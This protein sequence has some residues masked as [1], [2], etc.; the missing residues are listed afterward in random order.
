MRAS[1][2]LPRTGAVS[3]TGAIGAGSPAPLQPEVPPAPAAPPLTTRQQRLAQ[4]SQILQ[5]AVSKK[6]QAT[7]VLQNMAEGKPAAQGSA[8]MKQAVSQAQMRERQARQNA[9]AQTLMQMQG[10]KGYKR[11]G[12]I[13]EAQ[14]HAGNYPKGHLKF[15]GLDISIE[16][17]KGETRSGKDMDG[18]PWKVTMPASYGYIRRTMANDGEHVDC[19]MGPN[20]KSMR[21]YLIDQHHLHNGRYDECKA[22]LGFTNRAEAEKAYKDSFSDGKGG[23][24]MRKMVRISISEFKDWLKNGETHKP[25]KTA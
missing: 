6:A 19:F 16:T 24:R 25:F 21:V 23:K 9:E 18:K 5:D 15:H 7:Q 10:P 14:K 22:M 1:Y 3:E 20:E 12:R 4:N 17:A 2:A 13:S 11:G 8:D